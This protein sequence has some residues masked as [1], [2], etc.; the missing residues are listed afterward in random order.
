M[1]FPKAQNPYF[2]QA[3]K[4]VEVKREEVKKG[5]AKKIERILA[6]VYLQ[7]ANSLM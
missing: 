4:E 5:D 3:K 2:A 1:G 7:S 6:T